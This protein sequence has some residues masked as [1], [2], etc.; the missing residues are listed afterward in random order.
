MAL[1]FPGPFEIRQFYTVTV[2]GDALEHVLRLS[3]DLTTPIAPG[4]DFTNIFGESPNGAVVSL[5]TLVDRLLGVIS[6]FYTPTSTN[7][8]RTELW[9]YTPLTFDANFVSQYNSAVVPS[10]GTAP[11]D[12][13]YSIFTFRTI[14]G[15]VMRAT[16]LEMDVARNDQELYPTG[17]PK[18]DD[19]FDEIVNP[20]FSLYVGRDTSRPFSALRVS[21]GQNEA[22]WRKRHR[23]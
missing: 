2:G 5:A 4:E 17:T 1:N 20:D 9:E 10:G 14:E 15:G 21:F 23:P 11:V 7:F 19:V 12:S 22:I 3:V 6:P 13:Y 16:L 18:L 8:G